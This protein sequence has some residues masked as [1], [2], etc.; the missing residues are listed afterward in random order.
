MQSAAHK[1]IFST[2]VA[3]LLDHVCLILNS[4]ED[5]RGETW[6]FMCGCVSV[7]VHVEGGRRGTGHCI[8][9]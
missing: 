3:T 6:L 1:V 8:F 9:G 5:W 7:Y 4:L 2:W